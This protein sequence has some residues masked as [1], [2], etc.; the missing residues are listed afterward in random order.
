MSPC[1]K[2]VCKTIFKI[3]IQYL[4]RRVIQYWYC[5]NTQHI[6]HH[7]PTHCANG[8]LQMQHW[9][10]RT[11]LCLS[12]CR[13]RAWSFSCKEAVR[14][15]AQF[16]GVGGTRAES[17]SHLA[18]ARALFAPSDWICRRKNKGRRAFIVFLCIPDVRSP[19]HKQCGSPHT[20]YASHYP[21]QGSLVWPCCNHNSN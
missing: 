15:I 1:P 6:M 4:N 17:G 13:T 9:L 19:A 2:K 5:P 3:L 12:W 21:E 10:R 14:I 11:S 8:D 16:K 18:A 20:D 7:R